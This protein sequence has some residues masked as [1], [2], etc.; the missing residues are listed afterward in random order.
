MLY[1]IFFKNEKNSFTYFYP[2][3]DEF[4]KFLQV[5]EDIYHIRRCLCI[6]LFS[7]IK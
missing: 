1:R 5:K 4:G 7:C 3:M 2:I 6:S